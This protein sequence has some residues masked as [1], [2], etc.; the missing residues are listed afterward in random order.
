MNTSFQ[1]FIAIILLVIPGV[2]ATYGFLWM[3]NA[4]FVLF[5]PQPFPWFMFVAGVVAFSVGV[6]F[7]AGWIFYRD[8]KRN[9]VAPRFREKNKNKQNPNDNKENQN[10]S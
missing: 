9:Y 7:I 1:R 5:S 10:G 4:I 2:L 8:R 3:K 6:A